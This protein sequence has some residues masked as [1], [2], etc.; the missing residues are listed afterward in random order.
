VTALV[1]FAAIGIGTYLIRSSMFFALADRKLPAW[2]DQAMSFVGPAAIAALVASATFTSDG[3]VHALPV[4]EL[5]AI[6]AGFI[7]VRRTGN[8]L[9][10]LLVG[11]PTMWVLAALGM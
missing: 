11:F 1:V 2:L 7:V 10:A 5:V 9:H 8:V 3:R 6:A 4:A